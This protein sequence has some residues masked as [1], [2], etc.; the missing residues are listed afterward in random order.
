MANDK[1]NSDEDQQS[2]DEDETPSVE[3]DNLHHELVN[4]EDDTQQTPVI[5][6]INSV[7]RLPY[8]QRKIKFKDA[9]NLTWTEGEV[10]RVE[11]ANKVDN[12]V[13]EVL[14]DNDD[15]QKVDMAKI[16]FDWE[17]IKFSCHLCEKSFNMKK[18]LKLH[19][20]KSHQNEE[21]NDDADKDESIACEICGI[22]EPSED[23]M[24]NHIFN[25]HN[26]SLKSC[27][28]SSKNETTNKNVKFD[29]S[30]PYITNDS[31]KSEHT[32]FHELHEERP[33]NNKWRSMKNEVDEDEI[34]NAEV[35]E[36]ESNEEQCRNAKEKELQNF[37]E[38]KVFKEVEFEGQKV[39]GSRFVL[40]KKDNGSIKARFVV[41]GFQETKCPQTDSPTA[42][43]D[44]L[45]IFCTVAANEKWTVEGS[46]VT[47][48]FLQADKLDR[49]V[50][51]E[52][53]KE[54][55]KPGVI[56][57]LLKPCYGLKDASRQWY[58]S[59]SKYLISLGMKQSKSDACLFYLHEN[60]KLQGI[61][62]MHVDDILSAGTLH[63]EN[64]IMSKLR[65]KYSFGKIT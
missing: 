56:W 26:K 14:L 11:K 16:N 55:K 24:S 32:R 23:A 40:T 15:I 20:K 37:D 63:F 3:E 49:D 42:S 57:K 5:M 10:V 34:F 13:V 33:N 30:V 36:D 17:Y 8:I 6:K 4:T 64:N 21:E 45:K 50:Y 46:D 22:S 58:N 18:G 2:N 47:A 61:L 62:L 65:Q 52:P 41:K 48:A 9:N 44:T 51:I 25:A 60:D 28:R 7:K 59:S 12:M 43:R 53:P 29:D 39:I 38:Y 1:V 35:V 27:I 54:R 31:E 19:L